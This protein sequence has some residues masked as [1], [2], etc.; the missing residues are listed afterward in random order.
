MESKKEENIKIMSYNILAQNLL[1]DSLHLTNEEI[2]NIPYL[3][4]DYRFNK[5]FEKIEELSPDI[6]LFQE[7]EK[8]GKLK[9]LFDSKNLPYETIFK[10]RPG[11]HQEGCAIAYNKK[12]F[13]L[14]YYCSL[15]RTKNVLIF[16]FFYDRDYNSKIIK[17]D[18][19]F[20][21]FAISFTINALF[22]NDNTMHKIYEDKGEFQFISQLPQII[23]SS[24]ISIVLET[25]LNLLALSEDDIIS[26]KSEKENIGKIESI[27]IDKKEKVINKKIKIKLAFYFIVSTVLLLFFWYYLSMFC[28][29]YKN[30]QIHLIKDTLISFGVSLLYPFFICLLPGIFRIPSLANKKRNRRYLYIISKI[31]QFF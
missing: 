9:K 27:D 16:S 17:I 22:F 7:F 11:D 13:R 8:N 10:I 2:D 12:K 18:L 6:C 30:T 26:L 23:F 20:V 28:A 1:S 19:F 15:V 24:L 14:E 5:I 21:G 4:I 31:L 3:G 25:L 29:V